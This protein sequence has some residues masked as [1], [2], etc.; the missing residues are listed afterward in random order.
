MNSFLQIFQGMAL[1]KIRFG[2]PPKIFRSSFINSSVKLE[3][4]NNDFQ[5][6]LKL[7]E[8][9]QSFEEYDQQTTT[10]NH[11]SIIFQFCHRLANIVMHENERVPET[12]FA[13]LKRHESAIKFLI[14]GEN[15]QNLSSWSKEP[16]AWIFAHNERW[17]LIMILL[18]LAFDDEQIG[19]SESSSL[20]MN[21]NLYQSTND[22]VIERIL[23]LFE[24]ECDQEKETRIY[25]EGT[26]T[27]EKNLKYMKAQFV[28]RFVD[29]M[30]NDM[31][32]NRIYSS[33]N[34]LNP[35]LISEDNIY[36]NTNDMIYLS[37]DENIQQQ[38]NNNCS[39]NL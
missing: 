22:T 28:L 29:M 24:L 2:K 9:Y 37:C 33:N 8:C 20:D 12:F 1:D 32:S 3:P 10:N 11:S 39:E 35:Y 36:R 26:I 6:M 31:I 15:D 19:G 5:L 27:S 7:L 38:T 30:A 21:E 34:T 14:T 25:T 18:I 4:N 23:R 16:Q 17:R 13:R